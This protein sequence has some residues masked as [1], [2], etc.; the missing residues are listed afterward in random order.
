MN[1]KDLIQNLNTYWKK[2]N[3]F[4]KSIN[5]RSNSFDA[6]MY[7]GP[8]FASGT[9]HFG[10][11]LV[12]TMKDTIGRY[13]TMQWFR[14][15]RDRWWDCHGLPVE[16]AVEKALWIDGKK[17]IENKVGI[18]KFTDECRK[19][20]SNVSGERES[21]VDNIGRRADMKNAYMTMN[22]DFMES[23]INIFESLYNKNLVYKW[24][25]V[26][27]YCPSCATSLANNEVNEWYEDRQDPAIT[28]KFAIKQN[29]YNEEFSCTNDGCIQV[30]VA[31]V[32]NDN[33]YLVLNHQKDNTR[34]S[35]GGKVHNNESL[36]DAL[37][38]EVKE[39]LGVNIKKSKI[40]WSTKTQSYWAKRHINLNFF[41][42]ELDGEPKVVED[43]KHTA[44]RWI[45]KIP[46]EN[47]LGFGIKI[48]DIIIEMVD[49]IKRD[50]RQIWTLDVIEKNWLKFE[51]TNNAPVNFLAWT[52]TPW[53]LPSNSF[54]AVGAKIKYIHIWDIS[55]KEY[56]II[57]KSLINKYYKN[58]EDYVVIAEYNWKD[59]EWLRY[60]PIFPYINQ[61]KI[62][63]EYK[64]KYFHVITADYVSTEDGTGIVHIAPSLWV[65][66]FEAVA[67]KVFDRTLAKDWLF[68]PINDYGE[69]TDEVSDWT[70]IRVYDANKDVIKVLKEQGKLVFQQTYTHSYPH[71]W[72]CKTPLINKA[73]DSW[74]IKE[75]ELKP[76]T[77]D[78]AKKI[79]FVPET[80]K[81]RFIDT[82]D[83]APDWNLS[84]NR[85]RGSPIPI[86]Q[87]DNNGEDRIVV[88]TL[89]DLYKNTLTWSKNIT[90]HIFIRHAES[91]GNRDDIKDS[92][93]ILRLSEKG[94]DQTK[95]ITEILKKEIVW[96]DF[97]VIMSPLYRA[98]DTI[99][100]FLLGQF[101]QDKTET[102]EK[103][104]NEIKT[105]YEELYN[106]KTLL[107]YTLSDKEQLF[108]IGENIFVDMRLHELYHGSIDGQEYHEHITLWVPTNQPLN[109]GD[110]SVDH[111]MERW[112]KYIEDI[113]ERFKNKLIIS[114]SHGDPIV[115][116]QWAFRSFD[117]LQQKQN[118]YPENGKII[119]H[120]WDNKKWGE[121][122]LHRPHVD[123]YWFELNGNTY[124][125]IPEVMDCWFE[126]GAMP[127]GQVGYV[128]RKDGTTSS[129]KPLIYP[130][131]FIIEW[132]DQT[133]GWFRV[134][135]VIG[136][137]IMGKNSFNNVVINGLI[138]AEDGKK[139]SKSL[140]NYPEPTYLF[141]RYGP[142][143]YRLYVMSS[144][145]VKAESMR[146]SEKWVDQ[147]Y[148]DF[149]AGINNAYK[150]FETYARVDNF[151]AED[152]KIFF[153]RHAKATWYNLDDDLTQ[154]GIASLEK[155][156][157]IME[158]LKMDLD[159]IYSSPTLR[160]KKTAEK[161]V[162]I[163]KIYA[164]KDIELIVDQR[165]WDEWKSIELYQE[166]IKS[167]INKNIAFISHEIH[168]PGLW[169][170]IYGKKINRRITNLEIVPL[171]TYQITN[172]LD[173]WIWSSLHELTK[174][175]SDEM[176]KHLL[177]S[178][179]RIMM[180]FVDKL[181]NWFIRRSR[182][183]FWSGGMWEDKLSAYNTLYHILNEYMKV[184]AS[185]APFISE[186]IY[187]KL[188]NFSTENKEL[189][190]IHLYHYPLVNDLYVDKNLVE[191][192]A[193]V[194][195]IISMGLFIRSKNNIK[196]K[197]PLQK[198]SIK[199]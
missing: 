23:V 27:R 32:R 198:L 129:K 126:S 26:Q 88:G 158:I 136:N 130:A 86:W 73:M 122:D 84:R 133:R 36:E 68:L 138:L 190:S 97:V 148:K 52:T 197:Q 50:F 175:V 89:D 22:L 187:L 172:D 142:D 123:N 14:V 139:M 85:Y 118:Y 87:N 120:Y 43:E 12:S 181:T 33:K 58:K 54:L 64:N 144:P 151:K 57:A 45:E 59:L 189:D 112:K 110:E 199:I 196:V 182:R 81:K 184:T 16:K 13:K 21:F 185:F 75:P 155:K 70:G 109:P 56:F 25:K 176:D 191:E 103:K 24:F 15:V 188:K 165:L 72:R 131:D 83:S 159:K 193:L 40:I 79:W 180:W 95:N 143:A 51:E 115:A 67:N 156:E 106:N 141:N 113:S 105:Q 1:Q 65:D 63:Q 152:T 49:E 18:E 34:R 127:F 90:K 167:D 160:T 171:L 192:I 44:L 93:G 29:Q 164:N 154:E 119:T 5:Q 161:I 61:S 74:F 9:P 174:E 7:D 77:L 166:V 178:A 96:E 28:I 17:D 168:L 157:K 194:R 98:F 2:N 169:E 128:K 153:V 99:K 116:L 117:Y 76:T 146:F 121:V 35:A 19:Y 6:A 170:Y 125:R 137:A 38:R 80:V 69:F 108:K 134:M 8:P 53:T 149:T 145:A 60:E 41:E 78:N 147:V 163:Y 20:V 62:A 101:W 179:T 177:D 162:E 66:D 31:I 104:Y 111:M 140:N 10:H 4:Q 94:K 37:A 71:C 186:D 183:R 195:K 91:T 124:H 92:L 100:T 173:R 102:I 135:H 42:V 132:L 114:V 150:F 39:E 46:F 47:E 82:L 30:V 107:D 55:A 3:I 48:D 11:G